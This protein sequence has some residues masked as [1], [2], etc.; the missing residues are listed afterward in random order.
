M[1]GDVL[2]CLVYVPAISIYIIMIIVSCIEL[3]FGCNYFNVILKKRK[4]ERRIFNYSS[5]YAK[6]RCQQLI[7]YLEEKIWLTHSFS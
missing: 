6:H 5:Q 3:Y 4:N 2:E 1:K 7:H